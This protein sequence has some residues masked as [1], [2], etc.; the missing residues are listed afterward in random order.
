MASLPGFSA[1]GTALGFGNNALANQLQPRTNK[2]AK[3]GSL[4]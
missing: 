4:Q 3:R 1:A 2:P